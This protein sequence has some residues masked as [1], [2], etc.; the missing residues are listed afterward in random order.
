MPSDPGLHAPLGSAVSA[1]A[2]ERYIGRWSRLFVPGLLTAAGVAAGSRVLDVASGTGE[3]ALGA[4]T[5]VGRT[6]MVIASDISA[7]ML[8]AARSRFPGS[9]Q[10]VVTDGQ[11]LAFR[12]ASFDAVICQLGLMF[13]PNPA[14]GLGEFRR[15]LH[16]G[17]G[18][19]VCVISTPDRAPM[20]GL[21]AQALSRQLPAQRE[22]LHLSFALAD[23]DRLQSLFAEA[24]FRDIKVSREVRSGSVESFEEYWSAIETGTG[25]QPLIYASLPEAQRHAVRDEV[26]QGLSRFELDGRLELSVEM[27]IASGRA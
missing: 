9:Y 2:Y 16:A 10:A 7:G 1:S 17:G 27:L 18:A 11:K 3:A 5:R 24:G 25:Q 22:T 13:F 4:V 12:D 6:G 15:M 26:R 19:A 14:A 21:L 23:D 20:W 8:K